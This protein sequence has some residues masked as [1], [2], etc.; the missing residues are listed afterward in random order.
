MSRVLDVQSLRMSILSAIFWIL[1]CCMRRDSQLLPGMRVTSY[2]FIRVRILTRRLQT[3]MTFAIFQNVLRREKPPRFAG[4][5]QIAVLSCTHLA[6]YAN[7]QEVK[8]SILS[9]QSKCFLSNIMYFAFIL[10]GA[11]GRDNKNVRVGLRPPWLRAC[12]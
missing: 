12:P 8:T 1:D 6:V 10:T 4:L 2:T 9:E 7:F 5:E 11:L 3:E